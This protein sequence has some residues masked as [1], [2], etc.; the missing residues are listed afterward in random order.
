MRRQ[1]PP[2]VE[3]EEGTTRRAARRGPV[4]AEVG[5]VMLRK[6]DG[7]LPM[8]GDARWRREGVG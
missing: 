8:V 2:Q 1:H 4:G 3:M 7:R 6:I 5:P